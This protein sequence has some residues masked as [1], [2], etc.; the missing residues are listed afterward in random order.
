M[1]CQVH[2][3]VMQD[4]SRC[5]VTKH[6]VSKNE[7]QL[8]LGLVKFNFYTCWR[9]LLLGTPLLLGSNFSTGLL[10]VTS[11]EGKS[12]LGIAEHCFSPGEG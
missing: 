6:S 5:L 12:P 1:N 4:F 2:G 9:L 7:I 10:L 8:T 3:M 11:K